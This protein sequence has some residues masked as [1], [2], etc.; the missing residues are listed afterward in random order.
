M[1]RAVP[2]GE[3]R[4]EEEVGL[5]EERELDCRV[6]SQS[7]RCMA[8]LKLSIEANN[9]SKSSFPPELGSTEDES[10]RSS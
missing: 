4:R 2:G 3:E 10:V 1:V 5:V 7:R 8:R 9:W 6:R